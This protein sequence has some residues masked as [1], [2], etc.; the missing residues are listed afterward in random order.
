MS[1]NPT[2]LKQWRNRLGL[3]QAEHARLLG[4]PK[5]TYSNWEK[6]TRMPPAAGVVLIELLQM[7]EVMAPDIFNI[8]LAN[9]KEE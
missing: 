7:I 4:I 5:R 6:G 9:A 8:R 3:T 2:S 1:F